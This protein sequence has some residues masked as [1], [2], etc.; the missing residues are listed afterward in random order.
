MWCVGGVLGRVLIQLLGCVLGDNRVTSE[1]PPAVVV[2]VIP[3]GPV[4]RW[5]KMFSGRRVCAADG[6]GDGVGAFSGEDHDDRV[7][8]D[9]GGRAAVARG[10]LTRPT[11]GPDVGGGDG[12]GGE[13]P[14]AADSPL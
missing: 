14:R 12:R 10:G 3:S 1:A 8:H 5:V 2:A 6:D 11:S 7:D 13:V 4:S 9:A